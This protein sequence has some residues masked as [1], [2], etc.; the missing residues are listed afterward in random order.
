MAIPSRKS[1]TA[2]KGRQREVAGVSAGVRGHDLVLY[3]HS[4]QFVHLR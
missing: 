1:R 3:I 2:V 4:D